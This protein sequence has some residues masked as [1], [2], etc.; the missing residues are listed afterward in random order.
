MQ[1]R[2]SSRHKPAVRHAA[3]V[4]LA[5]VE[6]RFSPDRRHRA[7]LH[8]PFRGR[9]GPT[10]CVIGQNPSAADETV[11]DRTIRYLEDYVATRVPR[12]A[13]L[14]ILNLYSRVDTHKAATRGLTTPAMD[15]LFLQAVAEHRQ[16]LLI[17]GRL[18]VE[19]AWDFPARARRL[20]ALLADREVYKFDLAT[21]YAPHPGNPRILYHNFDVTLARHDFTDLD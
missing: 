16:F 1:T 9:R 3:H 20:R 14:L 10:L 4:D 7:L 15:A 18:V 19:G 21:P 2:P 17:T 8:L 6:A 5:R 12:Y 13:G 11:A